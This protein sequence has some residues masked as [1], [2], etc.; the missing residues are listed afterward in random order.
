MTVLI[1]NP[2][3]WVREFVSDSCSW[4]AQ[5]LMLNLQAVPPPKASQWHCSMQSRNPTVPSNCSPPGTPRPKVAPC[6]S[7]MEVTVPVIWISMRLVPKILATNAKPCYIPDFSLHLS[8][9][10]FLTTIAIHKLK[11]LTTQTKST[12][13]GQ[14]TIPHGNFLVDTEMSL[15]WWR[16]LVPSSNKT[17][18]LWTVFAN[19]ASHPGHSCNF[20]AAYL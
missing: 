3:K 14:S 2:S 10:H 16:H 4:P 6:Y 20:L 7:S 19:V 8:V 18:W 17:D 13:G 15:T 5:S 12:K 9:F 11:Q 1:L